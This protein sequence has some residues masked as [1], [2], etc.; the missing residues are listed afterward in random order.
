VIKT[1]GFIRP[2]QKLK[3][4]NYLTDDNSFIKTVV[5]KKIILLLHICF[6]ATILSA[7]K[8]LVP[9]SQSSL[10]GISLP[11][12][13]KQDSRMLSVSA[14][15]MLLG[16]ETKKSNITISTPEVL[17]LP[18]ADGFNAASLAK[19]LADL[20]WTVSVIQEDNKYAW[21][22]KDNRNLIMYF[23]PGSRETGL[24]FAEAAS[25]PL[26]NTGANNTVITQ[27]ENNQQVQQEALPVQPNEQV[28]QQPSPPI[29]N[30][31]F[32]FTTTNFDDG[33]TSTVQ[34]DWVEVTKG[35]IKVLIHYPNKKADDYN[36]NLLDGL[37]NAW[38]V[39]VAPRYSSAANFEFKPIS[40]WQSMEFAEA[41]CVEKTSGNTVHVVLFKFNR[42]GGGGRYMEFIT[43]DKNSFE[44][45][46]GPYHASTSG[47]E[48]MENMAYRN[49]F[50]IAAADLTGKW[51]SNFTGMTQYVNA[52]TGASA[53]ADTH[54][55]NENF[56]FSENNNYKWDLAVANGFVGNIKFQSVKSAGKF[57]VINNWQVSFSDIEGKP[58][59]SNVQF[60]C[61]K[62]ARVLWIDGTGFGKKE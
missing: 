20:G 47:W 25:A 48:K 7:Q 53:G 14:A 28:I 9:V 42:S 40:D 17:V 36:P 61:I 52:N 22:Q 50:A 1:H 33:W 54:A 60:V 23:S 16:M 46:F 21:L 2:N 27:T 15:K 30:S 62:G 26:Q 57:T 41:D 11:T 3:K 49:K 10:T 43:T 44:Q 56:E 29:N 24:Y 5:M 39:L 55:S 31:G 8:K 32:A 38:D 6:C 4:L 59:T 58:K 37:K 34:E 18:A 12:G 19:D 51:T 13:S 45:E 35:A